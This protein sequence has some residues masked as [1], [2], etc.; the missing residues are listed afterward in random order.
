MKEKMITCK[1]CGEEIAKSAKS[2][3]KCGAKNKKPIFKKWWFWVIILILIFAAVGSGGDGGDVSSSNQNDTSVSE[4]ASTE[5]KEPE[6]NS[7]VS[8]E[9]KNALKKA[10]IYSDTMHMSK[11]AIYD[12]LVSE[13]GEQFP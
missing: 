4:P 1:A 2:C 3:P 12:Q 8:I 5:T 9:Y 6:E 10:E 11:A 7:N 13:Y